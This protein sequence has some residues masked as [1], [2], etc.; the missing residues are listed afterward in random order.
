MDLLV[1]V[2]DVAFDELCVSILVRDMPAGRQ[3]GIAY[4]ASSLATCSPRSIFRSAIVTK[5]LF[6]AFVSLAWFE[7][8]WLGVDVPRC[9]ELADGCLA[10]AIGAYTLVRNILDTDRGEHTPSHDN[11][12]PLELA[13]VRWDR[14]VHRAGVLVRREVGHIVS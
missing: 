8:V 10:H 14:A 12:L 3:S 11:T 9:C 13:W 2:Y 5:A 4:G 7:R 6:R 1:P